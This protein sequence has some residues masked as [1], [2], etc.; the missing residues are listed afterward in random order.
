MSDRRPLRTEKEY[1]RALAR[2][3]E[4][5]NRLPER[6]EGMNGSEEAEFKRLVALI[7][8]YEDEHYPIGDP[9]PIG[10]IEFRMD[11]EG[12]SPRDLVPM[13]GSPTQVDEVLS[14]KRAI[15]PAMARALHARLGI[16]LEVLL[17]KAVTSAES[18]IAD[19]SRACRTADS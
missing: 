10:A 1:E 9:S 12:L 3:S 13:I 14:G 6:A 19:S 2:V 5:M 18:G 15:T 11:Q 17:P 8:R 7:E 16:P 4:L